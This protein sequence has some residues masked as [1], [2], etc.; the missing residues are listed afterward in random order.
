MELNMIENGNCSDGV[1]VAVTN[2]VLNSYR[3]CQKQVLVEHM[4]ITWKIRE[5]SWQESCLMNVEVQ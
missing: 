4:V 1:F 5:S 2:R 3:E